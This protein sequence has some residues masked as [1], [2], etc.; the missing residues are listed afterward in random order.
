MV[1]KIINLIYLEQH[2]LLLK[3]S[4]LENGSLLHYYFYFLKPEIIHRM[5]PYIGKNFKISTPNGIS[6]EQTWTRFRVSSPTIRR[7]IGNFLCNFDLS[8]TTSDASVLLTS[9][10]TKQTLHSRG[11]EHLITLT[12]QFS[13]IV[14]P[15]GRNNGHLPLL[16]DDTT[17]KKTLF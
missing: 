16:L 13:H 5:L 8:C 6:S 15:H 10:S 1:F 2:H 3:I 9:A 7:L 11:S 14:W 4:N 12:M 17:E